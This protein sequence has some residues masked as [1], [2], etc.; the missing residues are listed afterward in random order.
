MLIY[1]LRS[2]TLLSFQVLRTKCTMGTFSIQRALHLNKRRFVKA[3]QKTLSPNRYSGLD[4]WLVKG[5]KTRLGTA[6]SVWLYDM[7][8]SRF[9]AHAGSRPVVVSPNII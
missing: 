5:V 8:C 7:V 9:L 1:T 4:R 6:M 2:I 3:L